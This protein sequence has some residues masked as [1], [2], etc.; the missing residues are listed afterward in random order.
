M[1]FNPCGHIVDWSRAPY[2]QECRFFSDD[3]R[4]ST[5]RWFEAEP[6]AQPLP[7]PS[8]ICVSTNEQDRYLDSPIG[9]VYG[10]RHRFKL[11]KAP[12]GLFSGHYCGTEKDFA[13]GCAYDPDSP[14]FEYLANGFPK[15]CDAP[16]TALGGAG[17]GGIARMV[18][19]VVNP[20]PN[21]PTAFHGALNTTYNYTWNPGGV[22]WWYWD[23]IPGHTNFLTIT[24]ALGTGRAWNQYSGPN[25]G[26]L[27][28]PFSSS[29]NFTRLPR[30]SASGKIWFQIGGFLTAY[31]Y[32]LKL[33]DH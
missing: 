32:V 28:V 22:Q 31:P 5:V 6:D 29:V 10:A 9:E 21:C 25:C 7:F 15:C 20:G 26:A 4:T 19:D 17:V 1:R 24:F 14:P 13:E 2:T 16:F 8:V 27:G 23:V 12:V 18:V 30:T 3:D 11:G 33:E